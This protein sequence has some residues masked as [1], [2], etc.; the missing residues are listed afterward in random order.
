MG[1]DVVFWR[2]N[3]QDS[4][5]ELGEVVSPPVVLTGHVSGSGTNQGLAIGAES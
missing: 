2:S 1:H 4:C 5:S 3:S